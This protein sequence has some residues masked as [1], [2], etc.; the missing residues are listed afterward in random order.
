MPQGGIDPGET[1]VDA[2]YRE[3]REETGLDR[4]QYSIAAETDWISYELPEQFWNEKVGRGQTQ[5]W[6]LCRMDA[7]DASI[8]PDMDEFHDFRWVQPDEV[9]QLT[10]EFR[11]PLYRRVLLELL[12]VS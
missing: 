12:S 6:F 2:L 5:R 1:S 9:V 8:I 4:H 11:Q 10:V 7:P 3:I